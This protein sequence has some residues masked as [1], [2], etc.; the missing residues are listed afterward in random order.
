VLIQ[1]IA[2]P[3]KLQSLKTNKQKLLAVASGKD[4]SWDGGSGFNELD[5]KPKYH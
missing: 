2:H 1:S 5:P 3:A 4:V